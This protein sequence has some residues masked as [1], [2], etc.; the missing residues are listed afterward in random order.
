MAIDE[1]RVGDVLADDTCLVNVDIV[2]VI[3]NINAFALARVGRFYNP[4]IFLALMLFQLLIV[5]V[6]V[7]KF[8]RQD[9]SVWC[10]VESS[11]PILFLHTYQVEAKSIFFSHFITVGEMVNFLE[12]VQPLVLVRFAAAT[13][14]E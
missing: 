13:G 5:V 14:P 2:D 11:L 10:Q 8:F 1:Q 12:F 3:H 4:N 9:I 6:K 7:A